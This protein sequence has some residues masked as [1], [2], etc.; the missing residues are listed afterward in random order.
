MNTTMKYNSVIL[1]LFLWS[2]ICQI[3]T[4]RKSIWFKFILAIRIGFSIEIGSMT[5]KLF[6]ELG[7]YMGLVLP[8]RK[9]GVSL[10]NTNW[11]QKR[12]LLM[13]GE[14]KRWKGESGGT[15]VDG[16]NRE[17]MYM[18]SFVCLYYLETSQDKKESDFNIYLR[19]NFSQTRHSFF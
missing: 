5:I 1:V 2:L 8:L 17:E 10:F 9:T 7:E 3:G 6:I 19:V 4:F 15:I 11:I 16:A 18:H 12:L 13:K 14:F